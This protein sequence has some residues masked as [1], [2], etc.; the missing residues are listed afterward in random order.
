MGI[1]LLI[2]VIV[3]MIAFVVASFVIAKLQKNKPDSPGELQSH[4]LQQFHKTQKPPE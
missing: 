4:I 3:L 1:T 2:L